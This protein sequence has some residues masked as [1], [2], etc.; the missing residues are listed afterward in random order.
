MIAEVR[1][2]RCSDNKV[3]EY[4]DEFNK[5]AAKLSLKSAAVQ[6]HL[7]ILYTDGLPWKLKEA[8]LRDRDYEKWPFTEV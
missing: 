7:K 2:I 6:E 4:T 1:A 8:M 5:K 3:T